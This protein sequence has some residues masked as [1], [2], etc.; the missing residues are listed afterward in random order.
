MLEGTKEGNFCLLETNRY[1]MY[2]DECEIMHYMCNVFVNLKCLFDTT[3]L[4]NL[5]MWKVLIG[6]TNSQDIGPREI[7]TMIGL[8]LT[9]TKHKKSMN[10]DK[11]DFLSI[12]KDLTW[13][14][15]LRFR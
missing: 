4:C 3:Q 12:S 2:F 10:W 9:F 14:F 7:V 11:M 15:K 6:Q 1:T 5:Y 8:K 13:P